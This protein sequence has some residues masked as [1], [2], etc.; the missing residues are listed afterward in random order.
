MPYVY[1]IF[2]N[3]FTLL[4]FLLRFFVF[5]RVWGGVW[6][7]LFWIFGGCLGGFLEGF[8]GIWEARGTR[9]E[10]KIREIRGHFATLSQDASRG[11]LGEDLGRIFKRDLARPGR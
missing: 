9:M 4:Y 7:N 3:V 6:G 8:G 10:T 1:R 11:G 5:G 2:G